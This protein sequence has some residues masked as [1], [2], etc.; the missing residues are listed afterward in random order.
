M[1]PAKLASPE[2]AIAAPYLW[3]TGKLKACC[4]L[5]ISSALYSH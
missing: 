5:P 3:R 2:T 1:V 4:T